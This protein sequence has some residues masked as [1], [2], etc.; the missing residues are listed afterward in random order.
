[1]P[2]CP[3]PWCNGEI[4]SEPVSG[5]P[6]VTADNLSAVDL[7]NCFINKHDEKLNYKMVKELEEIETI[8]SEVDDELIRLQEEVTQPDS[9]IWERLG[10][11]SKKLY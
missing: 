4:P 11:I 8:I 1:M 10:E 9:N 7:I 2:D 5:A 3:C 6:D